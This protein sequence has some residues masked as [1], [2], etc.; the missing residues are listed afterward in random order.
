MKRRRISATRRIVSGRP[1]AVSLLLRDLPLPRQSSFDCGRTRPRG[2]AGC[3]FSGTTSQLVAHALES[4]PAVAGLR[5][6]L[7]RDASDPGG[8]MAD[9]HGRFGLVFLLPSGPGRLEG[10]DVAIAGRSLERVVRRAGR[11]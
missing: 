6:A 2:D 1:L 8:A 10:R 4:E 7:G 3:A 11:V 9:P 5:A